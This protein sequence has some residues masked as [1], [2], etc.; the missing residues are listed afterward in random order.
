MIRKPNYSYYRINLPDGTSQPVFATSK[1]DA[2]RQYKKQHRLT[3]MPSNA[4][5]TSDSPFDKNQ[6]GEV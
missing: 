3:K 1:N 2:V 6:S 5:I 4:T